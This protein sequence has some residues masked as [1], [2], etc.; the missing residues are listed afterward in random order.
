M[1]EAAGGMVRARGVCGK[2][3][4]SPIAGSADLRV[5]GIADVVVKD[6]LVITKIAEANR[7][8]CAACCGHHQR[9]S[10]AGHRLQCKPS[11]FATG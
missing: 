3:G 9:I 8:L 1:S 4:K 5:K 7:L 2:N 6:K 10:T 11:R